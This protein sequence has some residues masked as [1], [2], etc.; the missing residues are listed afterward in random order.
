MKIDKII[1]NNIVSALEPDGN[2]VVVMGRGIGFGAKPGKEILENKIE[3]VFRLDG[4]NSLDKFKE[5]LVNLPLEHIQVSAEIINYAK[6]VLNRSLNENIFITLTDHINFAIHRFRQRMVFSNPLLNDIKA[7]YKEEYLIGEYAVALIERT[8]GVKLPVDEAGFIALHIVNAEFNT[9][10]RDT[11]D[12]TNL[13]QNVVRIV[14]EYFVMEPDEASLNYQRFVT[15]LR[16]LAHR[17]VA[18]ELLNSGNA[19]FNHFISGMYPE[20]YKCSLKIRDYILETYHHHVTE[21]ETAY[22]AVHIKRLRL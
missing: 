10:M 12:I 7:F 15:H 11:I 17:I 22:L 5:L 14:K 16:F 19:E 3:K 20:E 13:I 4:Q 2:E 6:S 9:V 18:K 21:E 1:N 8:I